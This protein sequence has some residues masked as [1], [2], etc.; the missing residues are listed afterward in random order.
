MGIMNVMSVKSELET[1]L[2]EALRAG[3]DTRKRTIRM[4]ISAIRLAEIENRAD[5]EDPAIFTILQKEVKSRRE[6]IEEA[7]IARR[8]DL[9][10]AA[11]AE[12]A[13]LEEYLPR[14][15][16]QEELE[17]MARAAIAEVGA[18]SPEEMGQVMKVLMPRVQGRAEGKQVS[19]VVRHILGS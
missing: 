10:S 17:E 4:A 1:A 11:R 3:D 19:Q 6:T 5:L 15:L 18:S 9:V 12:I 13:I 16:T 14:P 7:E 8:E 2:K